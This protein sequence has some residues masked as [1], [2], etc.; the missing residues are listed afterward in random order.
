MLKSDVS[1]I[2]NE[3]ERFSKISFDQLKALSRED[4]APTLPHPGGH[5][6]LMCGRA[7]AEKIEEL[8]KNYLAGHPLSGRLAAKE[9]VD[10]FG[11]ELVCRFLAKG[12]EVN[13]TQI[14]EALSSAVSAAAAHLADV[15]HYIPCHLSWKEA[16][17]S[18]SIGPVTFHPRRVFFE[19]IET[20]LDRYV[21]L[22][23]AP[24]TMDAQSRENERWLLQ[25]L[26][27]Q[28]TRYYES[29]KW[30]AEVEIRGCDP[31][32]S[33]ERAQ[34]AVSSAVDVLHLLLGARFSVNMRAGGPRLEEDKRASIIRGGDGVVDVFVSR[35]PVGQVLEQ[36]W[37]EV[38]STG[39][40]NYYRDAAGKSLEVT[41]DPDLK[42]PLSYR[43]LEALSWFGQAVR[44]TSDAAQVIKYVTSIEQMVLTGEQDVSKTVKSRAAAL[45]WE[46]GGD[47]HLHQ[48][49][50]NIGTLYT[51]RSDLVH[52]LIS[53]FDARVAAGVQ[54]CEKAARCV[55][56]RGLS[57]FHAI[58]LD[59]G[60]I[61]RK[62]LRAFYKKYVHNIHE[63]EKRG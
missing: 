53:P 29:F 63:L 3:I 23:G 19:L 58:G 28:A 31:E 39:D 20:G 8:A 26:R 17:N 59:I 57:Y 5:G 49:S 24:P 35:A 61:S 48:W 34:F 60:K 44:E 15:V 36:N 2:I 16:R 13:D 52:G 37:W 33:R 56:I 1:F 41:T 18:F 50:D 43:F 21:G 30:V 10:L 27:D 32:I 25:S 7:A 62:E 9:V 4:L 55:L 47:R 6:K 11:D 46:P 38:I 22:S 14:E 40:G 12:S 45:C 42:R 54:D 51:L